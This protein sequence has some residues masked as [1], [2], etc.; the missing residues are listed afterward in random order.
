MAEKIEV[1]PHEMLR[2]CD[3]LFK[4]INAGDAREVTRIR[5]QMLG[6]PPEESDKEPQAP[7]G[8]LFG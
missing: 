4:A 7:A 1:S 8:P 5:K 2:L 3:L 6:Y